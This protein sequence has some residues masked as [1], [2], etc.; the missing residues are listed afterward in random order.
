MTSKNNISDTSLDSAIYKT[1][2]IDNFS[3]ELRN[4]SSKFK[5]K[6]NAVNELLMLLK[7]YGH[8]VPSDARTLLCTPKNVDCVPPE[9]YYHHG[10]KK[11]LLNQIAMYG[12]NLIVQNIITLN[13]NIDGLPISKSSKS[14]LWPILGLIY[15]KDI[16][17]LPFTIG[18]YH[19]Y[20]KPHS[21]DQYL[22]KFCNEYIDLSTN[23]FI[24]EHRTILVKIRAFIFD[25]PARAYVICTK[26]HNS[27]FG[28]SKCNVEGEY[29]NNRVVFLQNNAVERN[30]ED[31][32][33]QKYEDYHTG[34]S[35]LTRLDIDMCLNIPLDYMH[36]VCIGV[37][38]KLIKTWLSSRF[39]FRLSRNLKFSVSDI[40]QINEHLLLCQKYIPSEFQRKP[41][42]LD[43]IDRW[44]ASEFRLFLLYTGPAIIRKK[45]KLNAYK[46]F[47]ALHCAMRI[48]CCQ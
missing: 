8:S 31:F 15:H 47:L 25:A 9:K 1:K 29:V 27:Y 45:L 22:E 34:T 37:V 20:Q 14:Q 5:I 12:A 30:N 23:G 11:S 40:N 16:K 19:G 32:I 13:I 42:G 24:F 17:T 46:H 7:K 26:Y 39:R 36:V 3:S 21:V 43:E 4:W 48:L 28:C 2:S 33:N 10:L 18:I 6:Q 38:K 35:P 41:G 44:K